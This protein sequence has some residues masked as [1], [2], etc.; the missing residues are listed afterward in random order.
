MP[1]YVFNVVFLCLCESLS[2]LPDS[3]RT[4]GTLTLTLTLT[5]WNYLIAPSLNC[6]TSLVI[7]IANL[8]NEI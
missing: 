7:N 3:G 8:R 1:P 2:C 6:G 5:L 4:A